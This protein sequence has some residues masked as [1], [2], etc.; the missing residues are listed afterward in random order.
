MNSERKI[1]F[2]AGLSRRGLREWMSSEGQPGYRGEQVADW[3]FG[4]SVI[5]PEQMTNLP[6]NLRLLL[7]A[8]FHAPGSGVAAVSSSEDGTEK[9]LIELFDGESVEMVLIPSEERLTFC[10]STQVGCPVQCRFCA[11]GRD[12]LVR[13]LSAG[14]IIEEFLLGSERAGR[15]PDNLVF[16]GIG[17][18]LLN[19][20]E[21]VKALVL[22]SSPDEFGMSP[23]RITVLLN[24]WM[25]SMLSTMCSRSIYSLLPSGCTSRMS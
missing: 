2:L 20:N 10:L 11:S 13:N 18:G 16:M 4:R 8:R 3:I 25:R 1:P 19:Y 24:S 7:Q 6:A 15:R 14:E 5:R 17:E 12:G 21:L 9:L 22:L 23:R